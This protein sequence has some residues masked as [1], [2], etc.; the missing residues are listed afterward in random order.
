LNSW[1]ASAKVSI[2]ALNAY[3]ASQS[4]ASIIT[5]LTNLNAFTASQITQNT[6]LA[7]LTSSILS[8]TASAKVEL[9]NLETATSSLQSWSSSAKIQI[10][11]LESKSASVDISIANLNVATAS[12]QSW[13]ASAKLQIADLISKTGSYATTGSNT[14]I[15]NQTINGNLNL[16]GSLTAS[17]LH[18]PIADNGA[19]SFMQTD[20]AGNLSFQYVD[21]IWETI[22]NG[23]STALTAGTPVYVSGSN[24]NTPIAYRADASDPNKMPVTY[25]IQNTINPNNNGAAIALGLI[26]GVTTTGYPAG[27]EVF[28]A[29]GGGWSANRPTG[30]NSIVQPL[31]IVTKEGPGGSG[32][33]IV[34]NPGPVLLPNI[35]TGYLWVGD[36]NNQPISVATS[37]IITNIN[38]G[39][40]VTTSSFNTYTASVNQQLT[41]LEAGTSSYAISSSVAAVDAAQ[42]AQINSLIAWTG[43]V[44]SSTTIQSNGT[45]LGQATTLNFIGTGANVS[46]GA[47]TASITINAGS[48]SGGGTAGNSYSS[49]FMGSTWVVNHNLNTSVPLVFAYESG[50]QW[51]IPA[52]LDVTSPNSVTLVFSSVVSGSVVVV[53]GGDQTVISDVTNATSA[54]ITH[55]LNT[56]W[57]IVQVYESGSRAQIIP[58][59]VVSD[60]L[61]QITIGFSTPTSAKVVIKK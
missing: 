4:T 38:T 12:L 54:T 59:S 33:G 51:V 43:S 45:T 11:N 13:S 32:R 58:L 57:P 49:T 28:V 19:K 39:S 23:E 56:D 27:T 30:S 52:Q 34:L 9:S 35:Q 17:G 41:S 48:G 5:S 7:Q 42:Q 15:G 55:N 53:N 61:N 2:S 20:G 37:S 10:A 8:W 60:S 44:T 21:T 47:G 18:Y 36:A 46:V 14:F 40:L 26:T 22:R 25:V 29:E 16:T 31:G 24:G 50:S 1:S 6:T 3:T